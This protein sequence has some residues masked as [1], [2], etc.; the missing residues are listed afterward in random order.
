MGGGVY[1]YV[2]VC[3]RLSSHSCQEDGGYLHK[4]VIDKRPL[5]PLSSWG[6]ADRVITWFK[7]PP[8][9]QRGLPG[10]PVVGIAVSIQLDLSEETITEFF[11]N[12]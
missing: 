5:P 2:R 7:K 12:R 11:G 1:L 4:Q 8:K 6:M 10:R 9:A 3:V